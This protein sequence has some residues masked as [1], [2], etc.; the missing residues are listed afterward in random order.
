MNVIYNSTLGCHSDE[1]E[2]LSLKVSF[3]FLFKGFFFAIAASDLLIMTE[4]VC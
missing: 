1:D 2:F 3:S 4:F